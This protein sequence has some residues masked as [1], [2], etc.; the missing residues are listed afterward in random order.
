LYFGKGKFGGKK[1]TWQKSESTLQKR[2]FPIFSMCVLTHEI[3]SMSLTYE[4][5]RHQF[6][7]FKVQ[8][9]KIIALGISFCLIMILKI[10]KCAL[11]ERFI[12]GRWD[13]LSG[14]F[15]LREH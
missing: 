5:K 4:R 1:F 12:E 3:F 9:S 7:F 14:I 13:P 6:A 10:F 2:F 11:M 15:H 8:Y